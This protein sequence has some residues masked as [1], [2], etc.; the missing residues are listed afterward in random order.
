MLTGV[1]NALKIASLLVRYGSH[2]RIEETR[3]KFMVLG[4]KLGFLSSWTHTTS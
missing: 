1:T 3:F 4:V 2:K